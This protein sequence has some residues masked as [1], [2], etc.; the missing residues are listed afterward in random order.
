MTNHQQQ[1]E[2]S[3]VDVMERRQDSNKGVSVT[4]GLC[5]L[6]ITKNRKKLIATVGCHQ[7]NQNRGGKNVTGRTTESRNC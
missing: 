6:E 5:K 3:S 1:H 7:I 2:A 4:N